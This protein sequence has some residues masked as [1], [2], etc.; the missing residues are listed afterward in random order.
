MLALAAPAAAVEI[1]AIEDSAGNPV[2]ALVLNNHGVVL[3]D[4]NGP[5]AA[6]WDDGTV[7][8]LKPARDLA[9][10]VDINDA[11]QI[12]GSDDGSGDGE[13]T[14]AVVWAPGATTPT[15][16]PRLDPALDSWAMGI[17]AAGTVVGGGL[18][19]SG[20]VGYDNPIRWPGPEN[21]WPVDHAVSAT[22]INAGGS[23]LFKARLTSEAW[24]WRSGV[25]TELDCVVPGANN[26]LNDHDVLVGYER[27]SVPRAPTRWHAGAC[28]PLALLPGH[29][30]GLASA[31]NNAGA[32]VGI[33][34][35]DDFQTRTAVMWSP[36][37]AVTRLDDLLP[38]DSGW[39]LQ[40][41]IDIND[42]GQIIGQGV[43][44]GDFR[45]YLMTT[46]SPPGVEVKISPVGA[47]SAAQTF[48]LTLTLRNTSDS[49]DLEQV[50]LDYPH[51]FGVANAFYPLGQRADIRVVSGPQPPFPAT[52]AAGESS[53][54]KITM[55]AV[56]AGK[57]GLKA[58]VSARGVDS[59]DEVD[60]THYGQVEV[61]HRQPR[62]AERTAMVA[63]GIAQFLGTANRA[64]R[65][66]QARYA[67]GVFE[68][69]KKKL[70][71]KARKYY[72]GSKKE[73]KVTELERALA[74]WRNESPDLTALVT[75]NR[76]KPLYK[77]G[78]V[79]Y[80]D[81]QLAR[82][83]ELEQEKFIQLGEKF[84]TEVDKTFWVELGYW[85]QLASREGQ[86]RLAADWALYREYNKRDG[87]ALI[88]A[89]GMAFSPQQCT[90]ALAQA[91]VDLRRGFEKAV[92][93]LLKARDNRVDRLAKL[94][95][96]D[97]EKFMKQLAE[98]DAT[99]RHAA[100]KVL[101][102]QLLG[103][104]QDRLGGQLFDG[105]KGSV[106]WLANATK[107][108]SKKEARA[109]AKAMPLS[110]RSATLGPSYMDDLSDEAKSM[111]DLRRMEEIGGMPAEDVEITQGIVAGVNA[112]LKQ[113]GHDVEAE[114][115]FRPAN[116]FKVPG[117]FAKVETV[118]V[119]NIA[120]IDLALG[121][122]PSLLAETAVFKPRKPETLAGWKD[123][124]EAEKI[125]L[126]ERYETRLS[127]YRQFHGARRDITDKKMKEMVKALDRVHTFDQIGQ[128]RTI[129]MK[130]SRKEVDGAT[131]LKYDYL[132]VEGKVLIERN[133]KPRSIGTDYDGA[134][135]IDKETRELLKGQVLTDAEFELK[136]LG[137]KAAL[138]KG[139]A[140][141]FHGFTA[142]GADA[143]SAEY[144][145]IAHF[146]LRHLKEADAIREAQKLAAD[147][148]RGKLA[149]QM[150]TPA[151]LLS[152]VGGL[153][154]RHLLRISAS[155][156]SFGPANVVFRTPVVAP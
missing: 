48:D 100:F 69:L 112:R 79:Y 134:A 88:A 117:A 154:G 94:A 108:G 34:Q 15:V 132:E 113:R 25:R 23:I 111:I 150:V 148:N 156:V 63:A 38:A 127:E 1:R 133:G 71:P 151:Q 44:D 19:V 146:W 141:P 50:K 35:T 53:V 126:Q 122:P 20:G 105:L 56:Q 119:K 135:L 68:M 43:R 2:T 45:H 33:S 73:L 32:V 55:R 75:P 26:A 149:G 107:A 147:Y 42:S 28:T 54:H 12:V 16:L 137:E 39:T 13:R 82:H 120:P 99:L 83:E 92:D 153:F 144:P 98:D 89:V 51:G 93:G 70:S 123:Y 37:G 110:E 84:M 87:D 129:K 143:S 67:R 57:V 136:R 5:D 64:L 77:D 31:I 121:A 60:D 6:R 27:G 14:D 86:G 47:A 90:M 96:T 128:G 138:E 109:L 11:G 24:L 58:A 152:P 114:A 145:F 116:P 130:L 22:D 3:A 102:D 10:P 124:P 4:V 30:T 74:R 115:L 95:E 7:T 76:K 8:I 41:A 155:D 91:D 18:R 97:T 139:Y 103:D 36:D 142:S 46:D 65:E 29:T 72:F 62:G 118:G 17:N 61:A 59:D 52:L 131:V 80:T 81:S 106:A 9:L 140:N 78:F 104:V 66:Q 85:S 101:A 40:N 49:E 21:L 125:L